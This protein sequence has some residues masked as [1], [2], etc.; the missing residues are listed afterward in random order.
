MFGLFAEDVVHYHKSPKTMFKLSVSQKAPK[1][2]FTKPFESRTKMTKAA[3][4]SRTTN[5]KQN[6]PNMALNFLTFF[7]F[8][9][10]TFLG[11]FFKLRRFSL[12]VSSL[13]KI[14]FFT[15][16]TFFYNSPSISMLLKKK[17]TVLGA[18]HPKL[19]WEAYF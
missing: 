5:D 15:I 11:R 6:L 16:F 1:T 14:V 12:E 2:A 7:V 4:T 8:E 10:T 19:Q 13:L 17:K 9:K 3:W 18:E